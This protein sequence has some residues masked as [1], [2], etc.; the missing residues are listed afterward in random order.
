M[1]RR[2]TKVSLLILLGLVVAT[3]AQAAIDGGLVA[4]W[5]LDGNAEDA[6]GVFHGEHL[7]T[8]VYVAG[9]FGEAIRLNG[10]LNEYIA[11]NGGSGG[12]NVGDV[13]PMFDSA[14]DF[15]YVDG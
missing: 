10:E 14:F 12:N 9:K 13:D 7:G 3:P 5:P 6:L 4:Y 15:T 8:P 1:L 11:I 2:F